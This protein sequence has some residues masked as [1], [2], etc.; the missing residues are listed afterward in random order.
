M[1]CRWLPRLGTSLLLISIAVAGACLQPGEPPVML[2]EAI[3]ASLTSAPASR[4]AKAAYEAALA[5]IEQDRPIARPIVSALASG[6]LQGP[7]VTLPLAGSV[8][9]SVLPPQAG[10]LDI[11]FEMPLFRFGGVAAQQRYSALRSQALLEY[12]KS[13]LD[14][15]SGIQRLFVDL[16]QARQG[17]RTAESGVEAARRFRSLTDALVASGSGKPADLDQATAQVADAEAGLSKAR[18]GVLLANMALNQALGRPIQSA[19]NY[20]PLSSDAA[21]PVSANAAILSARSQRVEV[22]TIKINLAAARAG[23]A[24]AKSQGQPSVSARGQLTEQTPTALLHEHYAAASIEIKIPILDAGK[25]RS[26]VKEAEARVRQLEALLIQAETG[27]DL[28]VGRAWLNWKQS[29]ENQKAANAS[30]IAAET[31]LTVAETAFRVGRISGTEVFAA[32][33]DAR[34]AR[35]RRA[36]AATSAIAASLEFATVQGEGH[37]IVNKLA[38][39]PTNLNTGSNRAR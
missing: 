25:T 7:G 33:R 3:A 36:A 4:A 21:P 23:A 11:L 9:N 26:D 13:L 27:V 34:A 19:A 38:G 1:M 2:P 16:E 18:Y 15:S 24:L 35:E 28:D 37:P 39:I 8:P 17:V 12:R 22:L 5:G 20:A 29:V 31:A 14:I 6:T 10:R 32:Q 30:V